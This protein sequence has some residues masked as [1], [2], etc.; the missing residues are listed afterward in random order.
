MG[1]LINL[2]KFR[3]RIAR[4]ADEAVAQQ[5]RLAFG[6]SKAER[7]A[8]NKERNRAAQHHQAHER[9]APA[10]HAEDS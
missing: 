6:V 9:S 2:R 8:V 4:V 10:I 5:N 3:K 1:D 7:A